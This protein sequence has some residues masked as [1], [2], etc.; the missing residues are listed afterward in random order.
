MPTLN[1]T[2]NNTCAPQFTEEDQK[3]SNDY[4]MENTCN[5]REE[6]GAPEIPNED[7]SFHRQAQKHI[8]QPL[9]TK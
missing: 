1:E 5:V 3:T 8:T 7:A 2:L 9:Q 6:V 4:K